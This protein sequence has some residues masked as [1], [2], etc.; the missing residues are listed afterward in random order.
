MGGAV[1]ISH[2][3]KPPSKAARLLI[4]KHG[5]AVARKHALQELHNA[6]RARSRLR[7]TFWA[8]VI[9]EIDVHASPAL[10]RTVDAPRNLH[11]QDNVMIQDKRP[12][13]AEPAET[14][15]SGRGAQTSRVHFP[16]HWWQIFRRLRVG[17]RNWD[18]R[19]NLQSGAC[20]GC[21]AIEIELRLGDPPGAL[22]CLAV[23][24]GAGDFARNCLGER[25]ERPIGRDRDVQAVL[26]RILC[27][28][29]LSGRGLRLSAL[30]RVTAIGALFAVGGQRI[31]SPL[32]SPVSTSRNCAS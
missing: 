20:D 32:S 24:V 7:F 27:G 13:R 22:Q 29:R 15:P 1:V 14:K 2:Y 18:R 8:T 9:A 3:V 4:A 21:H 23:R 10:D 16:Q 17:S 19:A 12:I 30:L 26:Q 11:Y 5:A 31:G 25:W 6:R 28:A